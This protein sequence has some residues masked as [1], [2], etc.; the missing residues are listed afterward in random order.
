VGA[1]VAQFI[2][3]NAANLS[4]SRGAKPMD[5]TKAGRNKTGFDLIT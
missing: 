5:A 4:T 3:K 1:I 2:R